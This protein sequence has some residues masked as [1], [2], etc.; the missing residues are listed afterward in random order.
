[1]PFGGFK[2]SLLLALKAVVLILSCKSLGNNKRELAKKTMS[3][4]AL[5]LDLQLR[6]F[7]SLGV[8]GKTGTGKPRADRLSATKSVKQLISRRKSNALIIIFLPDKTQTLSEMVHKKKFYI[9][10]TQQNKNYSAAVCPEKT[11]QDDQKILLFG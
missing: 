11:Y 2:Q 9:K 10:K 1:M 6:V 3:I 7:S 5:F 4:H 8:D